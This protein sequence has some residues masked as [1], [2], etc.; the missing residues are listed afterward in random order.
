MAK[1]YIKLYGPPIIKALQALEGVAVEMSKEREVK[2]SHKCI[3]YPTRMQTDN[4]DWNAY[5]KNLSKTY[6]DCYE[7]QK[8]I[9]EA[10]EL[11]GEY[12]FVFEWADKPGFKQVESLI[13]K[14]DKA[15][16]GLGVFYTLE[17]AS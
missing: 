11:I 6:V 9:S 8:L 16:T 10:K 7:P 4:R 14:I 15:L 5:L 17:T 2:F 1:T 13:T 3:P 12:D